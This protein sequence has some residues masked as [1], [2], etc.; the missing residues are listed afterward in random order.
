VTRLVENRSD[1]WTPGEDDL[2]RR[3]AEARTPPE[4]IAAKLNR[5]V[6]NIKTRAYVI[7]LP[8]KWFKL[9]AKGK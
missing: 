1:P 4:L 3:M 7:G 2:F 8:L 9:K 5:S 6:H